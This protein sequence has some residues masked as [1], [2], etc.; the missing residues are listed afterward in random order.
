VANDKDKSQRLVI[1][2][3]HAQRMSGNQARLALTALLNAGYVTIKAFERA[4]LMTEH[5]PA[6]IEHREA[7]D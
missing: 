2:I 1:A 5:A 6:A 7:A 4:R 3:D